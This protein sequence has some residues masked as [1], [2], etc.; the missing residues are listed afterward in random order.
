MRTKYFCVFFFNLLLWRAGAQNEVNT[1]LNA[2]LQEARDKDV[3]SG[4][5]LIV[6]DG[7]TFFQKSTGMADF[8]TALPNTP[9]TRFSIGSIT[10]VFTRILVLQL[11][12]EGKLGLDDTLGKHLSGFSP[13]VAGRITL[14]HLLNH[15]SGL[16]Q[17]YDLPDFS[18]EETEIRSATD[19]LPWIRQENL[20][21]EPG[22]R[23]EYSNSG[24]VTL[25]AIVE[26]TEGKN[27]AEVLKTRIL[28]KIGMHETGFLFRMQ[29][30]PGKATGYL[31]NIPGP[32]QDNLGFSLLG[33]GDGGIYSTTGDLLRLSRSL[34]DDNLLLSDTNKLHLFNEPLFPK[35]YT[36][37]QE[38]RREGRYA[39]AG[40]GPGINA[41]LSLNNEQNRVVIVLSNYDEGS[42]EAIFQR[43]GAVL[44]GKTPEPL[45][46][47]A[48]RFIYQLLKTKGPAYFTEN[49]DR[50]LRDNGYELEDDMVLFFTGQALLSEG[51]ADESI[52]LYRYYT[53]RFPKIVVAWNDLGDAYLLK[54]DRENAKKCFSKA[55]E[56][57]PGN[58][59]AKENLDKL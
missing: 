12:A 5:V 14:R 31:S 18:P 52:A 25:A 11:V 53:D 43:I 29:Q 24:Y 2:L 50:D 35:Q 10:K 28:D 26:K 49:V 6:R 59:R 15:Q 54:N 37:W 7:Q 32:H 16:G 20:A 47:S 38:F 21:F 44:N 9:D 22:A 8:A 33:G 39:V 13:E 48:S 4:N 27:Y 51:K 40:G 3:F 55:L 19:F 36:S 58:A 1:S 41:V 30:L 57:R 46:P 17:Y 34:V 42:A 23:A 56:L 45:Q